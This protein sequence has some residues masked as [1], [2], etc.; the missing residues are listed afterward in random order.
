MALL[1]L[2]IKKA[3]KWL[4]KIKIEG[5]QRQIGSYENEEEAAVDYAR[6]V[7]KYRGQFGTESQSDRNN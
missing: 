3:N 5:K 7:F 1:G 2:L 6:A 4:A